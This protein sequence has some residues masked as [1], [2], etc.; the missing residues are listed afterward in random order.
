MVF[1][2]KY[3]KQRDKTAFGNEGLLIQKWKENFVSNIWA[4]V[5]GSRESSP[6][7]LVASLDCLGPCKRV[8]FVFSF[9]VFVLF[10]GS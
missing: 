5:K 3:R 1:D 10:F 9:A 8:F 2:V 7:T 6:N 4:R